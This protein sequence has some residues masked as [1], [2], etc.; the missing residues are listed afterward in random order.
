VAPADAATTGRSPRSSTPSSPAPALSTP[1]QAQE[2]TALAKLGGLE[3]AVAAAKAE[4]SGLRA[5]LAAETE[6]LAT[7]RGVNRQLMARKEEME[8]QLMA[9][10]SKV[11]RRAAVGKEGRAGR[12]RPRARRP[13]RTL[14]SITP[15]GSRA[16]AAPPRPAPRCPQ[17]DEGAMPHGGGPMTTAT[18]TG[19]LYAHVLGGS[20]TGAR[21]PRLESIPLRQVLEV[22]AAVVPAAPRRAVSP[23]RRVQSPPPAAYKPAPAAAPK[24]PPVP[25]A[26]ALAP[27]LHKPATPPSPTSAGRKAVSFDKTEA[28]APAAPAPLRFGTAAAPAPEPYA[29][30]PGQSGN[31]EE[32]FGISRPASAARRASQ[33]THNP[34]HPAMGQ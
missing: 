18:V 10:V 22:A 20:P 31:S 25:P 7:Q 30:A 33:A 11:R 8:W 26:P 2:Q 21:S 17:H 24:S 13:L 27:A 12:E 6:A 19:P 28:P 4:A 14:K 34:H 32:H 1:A 3:A 16:P 15:P 23:P 5:A 9:A 29:L